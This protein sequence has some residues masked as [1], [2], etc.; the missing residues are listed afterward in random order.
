MKKRCSR[1]WAV[2]AARDGRLGGLERDEMHRHLADCADCAAHAAWL[3]DLGRGLRALPFA[4]MSQLAARRQRAQLLG[5][6]NEWVLRTSTARRSV[7][8]RVAFGA[9]ALVLCAAG[10]RL[11][12][13]LW[14][15]REAV[16]ETPVVEVQA[17]PGARWSQHTGPVHRVEILEGE[18]FLRIRRTPSVARVVI[19]VPDGE[20]E[21]FGTALSV[22]VQKEE[23]AKVSVAEGEVELRLHGRPSVDLRA[24]ETWYARRPGESQPTLPPEVA[25]AGGE[26]VHL[27]AQRARTVGLAKKKYR[28]PDNT[29]VGADGGQEQAEDSAYV[30]IIELLDAGKTTEAQAAARAYLQRFPEGLRR[31]EISRIAAAKVEP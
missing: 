22:K 17:D 12:P 24:G 2:E 18:V 4:D 26:R 21:D 27:E 30:A 5:A 25:S 23:T 29:D 3:A 10:L 13:R 16:T 11:G 14:R 20:I 6:F 1:L 31:V 8:G 7:W 28:R 9:A 15:M 19:T